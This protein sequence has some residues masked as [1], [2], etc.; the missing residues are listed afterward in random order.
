MTTARGGLIVVSAPSG[1]GKTTLCRRLLE[2]LPG[3]VFSVSHTTRA[4]RAGERPGVDYHFVGRAEF[5]ARRAAGEFLEW[6]V[7]GGELYGTSALAAESSLAQ[8]LDVL[9]DVDTQGAAA[10]RRLTPEAVL[11]FILPPGPEALRA[12][13][14]A[15]GSESEEGLERR[16]CL[17]AA[18]VAR[19]G[20]YDYQ[21]I[22][23]DLDAAFDR[24]R[25][26]VVAS[27]CR[28]ARL[29]ERLETIAARFGDKSP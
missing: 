9:L 11:V 5:E 16:L 8:G 4:P 24:L 2:A 15:R 10:V 25:A 27:R 18:E 21:V 6:A 19:A 3:L 22:N 13:L 26:I 7:V 28:T 20:E 17:A 29:R 1:A 14:L 23:D 12:R